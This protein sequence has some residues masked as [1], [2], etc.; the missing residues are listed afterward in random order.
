MELPASSSGESPVPRRSVLLTITAALCLLPLVESA[1]PGAFCIPESGV[2]CVCSQGTYLNEAGGGCSGSTPCMCQMCPVG[3]TTLAAG[4][5]KRE[6]CS[7]CR[8]RQFTDSDIDGIKL[9]ISIVGCRQNLP[10]DMSGVA[11][12]WD[13]AD[14]T[15][16]KGTCWR[17]CCCFVNL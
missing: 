6:D 8:N 9:N 4:S 3:S 12:G 17:K 5:K 2:D 13:L 14:G 11:N 1:Y 15:M 10:C 7:A 16:H